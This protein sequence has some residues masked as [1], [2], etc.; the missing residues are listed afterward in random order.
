MVSSSFLIRIGR[1]L[2]YMLYLIHLSAC[3]YYSFSYAVGIA[4]TSF[5]YQGDGNASVCFHCATIFLW[6]CA[7]I[8]DSIDCCLRYVRC[9]YFALKT[10][11]KIG[12][13]PKP[14]QN[15]ERAFMIFN[16]LI[17]VFACAAIIGQVFHS[18]IHSTECKLQRRIRTLVKDQSVL[19]FR[20]RFET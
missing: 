11:T 10:A 3:A 5:V 16:W 15:I 12:K 7:L 9:F 13:N 17:G 14:I 20:C 18:D 6:H 19:K 4:S 8:A 1:T 2:F